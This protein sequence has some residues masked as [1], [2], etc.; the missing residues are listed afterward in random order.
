MS[1]GFFLK[2]AE[3][4]EETCG[5]PRPDIILELAEPT[6]T[7]YKDILANGYVLV[8][9]LHGYISTRSDFLP[10]IPLY[11]DQIIAVRR[12]LAEAIGHTETIRVDFRALQ[13]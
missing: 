5:I 4:I 3:A 9:F 1:Y 10:G 7:D 8:H 11:A 2:N 13:Q 12:D 6:T